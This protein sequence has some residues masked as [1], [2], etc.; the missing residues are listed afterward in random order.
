MYNVLTMAY[1]EAACIGMIAI[2]PIGHNFVRRWL[3]ALYYN[4]N[5]NA[6]CERTN[7]VTNSECL[8]SAQQFS[9]ALVPRWPAVS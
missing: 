2:E 5:Y 4:A 1:L 3:V 6:I 8:H 9:A 7:K